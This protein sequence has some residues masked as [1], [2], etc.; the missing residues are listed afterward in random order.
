MDARVLNCTAKDVVSLT[1]AGTVGR[2]GIDSFQK[3]WTGL[4]IDTAT[5]V[6]WRRDGSAERW[7]ILDAG[8]PMSDFV[9]SPE[10]SLTSASTEVLR[11]QLW[12]EADRITFLH[13]GRSIFVTGL[14]EEAR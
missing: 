11:I 9:A 12:A 14:C 4:R 2:F 6:I 13:F 8:S 3:D 10:R 5:G 7:A 1:E